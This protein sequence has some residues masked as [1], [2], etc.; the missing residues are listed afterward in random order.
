[1]EREDQELWGFTGSVCVGIR[2]GQWVRPEE[3]KDLSAQRWKAG[4]PGRDCKGRGV[5]WEESFP[6]AGEL[7]LRGVGRLLVRD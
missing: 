1:M 5:T 7:G 3:G 6:P 4:L 2:V